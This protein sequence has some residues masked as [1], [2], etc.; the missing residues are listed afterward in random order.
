MASI[1]ELKRLIDLHE[2]A[3]RLGIKKGKGGEKAN[4]HSPH[5]TD[6]KPSLSI[7][8]ALPERGAGWKDHST[9]KGGSCIDLVMYVQGCD[10]SEAMRYLHE[11]FGIPFD[12]PEKP[13]EQRRA[14][15][16]VDY[17][18]ERAI[19]L[20]EKARDYLKGRGITDAAIDRA[21]KCKTL[22]YNDWTSPKKPA[23]EVGHGGPAVVFLVHA[24]D[25]SQ[26]VATDMRYLD[27]ALNGDVKTMT[28]GE[29]DGHGWTADPRKLHAAH[30]VVIVE[31]AINALS[32]DSCDIPGT[33]AYALRGIGNVDNIDFA[34]LRGKQ[35]VICLDNDDVIPEG[36][37][38]AGERPGPDAACKLYEHL[39][40][41]NIACIL[42]DQSDWVKDLADGSKKAESIND[43]NDYL[44]LRGAAELRKA[45]DAYEQWLIP[46]M[47]GDATRKGKPRVFLPS[48]DFAQ[49][50]RF[51][52]RLDFTTFITKGG[53]NDDEPP[54]HID[55][56]GFRV[57]S[58][59]RVSVASASSTM[60]G[61]PDNAPTIYFAVTVQTPRHGS[62]LTRAVLNDKQIHNLTVWNQFGPIWEPKRFSRMVTI[63]ER[64]AHLGARKAAN[65]VGLAWRDGRLVVNEG[66]DCYFTNAEQQCPYH[67][68]TFPSGTVSDAAR[69]LSKYQE[70]FKENAATLALVWGLGGHLKA[71][72]G[73][74]P[75]MMMQADKSAGKSTLIKALERTIGFTMFSGQSLQTEFRL[76]TSISHTSHP[77]GWEELSARKQDVI[78]K[79]VG[80][81]QENYQ[82]TIT[83]RGSEMTEYVLSAPVLLAGEDVPVRSLHG[84]LVRTNLT[85]KKG[86]MLPRDLPRF[87]VR[88]WLQY[89]A[90][91]DRDIVLDKYE[92][93][94]AHCLKKSCG[95]GD[96]EGAKRMASNYA[97][98]LLA[99]GYLCDFAGIPTNAG[100]FGDDVLAEMNR[101]I[102]ETSADRSPWVWIL[103]T[104]LSEIDAGSFKHPHKFDEVDGEDCLLVRP[105]HIMDHI[106]GSTSLREKWNAL[107]VKTPAVFRRQL[108]AA[109]VTVGDK[110]IERTIHQ[111]RVAHLT[112]LSLKR[113]AGYGLSVAR[114]LTHVHEN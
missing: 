55:L 82:Y 78:D 99:W 13:A 41:L 24:L 20:R 88:Q 87:P 73:F 113:L 84:K 98:L 112:P 74:W 83:K 81:L 97:A 28:Q 71:L 86:T 23:G 80:L 96:D 35:V 2:L 63:L 95:S 100:A 40:S 60:T 67:N 3:D 11:T 111:K 75:H 8:P 105:S 27:P 62:N 59:S 43:V 4:Y 44:Q 85:G 89:L 101:H 46:G 48:H 76:L 66:P 110:E 70:T 64:S 34:F 102:A 54:T 6:K 58:F 7:F 109:G 22:G 57:A 47:A 12:T 93:L 31:S 68:L 51:R 91:L 90:E 106:A 36:K 32:V 16:A 77:V 25:G 9:G 69:V 92:E 107:P 17:I 5:T 38:R 37:P 72:L 104:A 103:E 26:L 61:D 79:A 108:L 56:A 33:A 94:R 52:S 65:Y 30:R 1:T 53:D 29:K 114:N 18:G 45:L 14:K 21:F 15:T 50:W 19:E 39:T 49:Y 10:V 42:V